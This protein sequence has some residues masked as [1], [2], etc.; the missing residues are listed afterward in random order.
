MQS[1]ARNSLINDLQKICSNVESAY[2]DVLAKLRPVKDSFDKPKN[3]KKELKKFTADKDTRDSFKPDK[4]C[5]RVYN[6]I[7]DFEDNLNPL[8]YSVD[9]KKL[10]KLKDQFNLIGNVDGALYDAYDEFSRDLDKI[11][12]E[13]NTLIRKK[14]KK[15]LEER[16]LYVQHLI[17][18]F[19]DEL[20]DAIKTMREA[21]DRILR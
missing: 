13:I 19:E 10:S 21:K 14:S 15:R 4:L 16:T 6:L 12:I 11:S 17:V 8:K 9:V 7:S 18:D 20:F 1:A 3:L 5:G 2:S